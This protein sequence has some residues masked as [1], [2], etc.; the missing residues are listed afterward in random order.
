MTMFGDAGDK[1]RLAPSGRRTGVLDLR[2]VRSPP[3]VMNPRKG[4]ICATVPR[5]KGNVI[6]LTPLVK[7]RRGRNIPRG[8]TLRRAPIPRRSSGSCRSCARP[9]WR[10]EGVATA[11]EVAADRFEIERACWTRPFPPNHRGVPANFMKVILA[12]PRGF[13]D[14]GTGHR[15]VDQVSSCAANRVRLHEIVTTARRQDFR[16][17]GVRS[18]RVGEG[19]GRAIGYS[20]HGISRP[21]G[22]GRRSAAAG[23]EVDR[24]TALTKVT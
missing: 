11:A 14:G 7:E 1:L 10:A 6:V 13:C 18:A 24:L 4:R 3:G 16:S 9:G 5:A 21:S 22:A 8:G 15:V 23:V 2:Q 17:R 12:T 19:G 20:A